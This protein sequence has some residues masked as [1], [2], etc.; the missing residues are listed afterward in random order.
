MSYITCVFPDDGLLQRGR[1]V[2]LY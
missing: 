1:N 2:P